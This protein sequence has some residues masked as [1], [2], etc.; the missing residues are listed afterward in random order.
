VRHYVIK[1]AQWRGRERDAGRGAAPGMGGAARPWRQ[2]PGDWGGQ[3]WM[4]ALTS[5][6]HLSVGA[7]ER[8]W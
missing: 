6:P 1:A 8:K 2:V 4:M 5:G 3:M 7:C